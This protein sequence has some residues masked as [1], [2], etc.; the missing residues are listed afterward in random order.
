MDDVLAQQVLRAEDLEDDAEAEYGVTSGRAFLGSTRSA[1]AMGRTTR[2]AG[3]GPGATSSRPLDALSISSE[4]QSPV[5]LPLPT[6]SSATTKRSEQ[7]TPI[8]P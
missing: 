8:C 3:V 6:P 7:A 1:S 2:S 4:G 5:P